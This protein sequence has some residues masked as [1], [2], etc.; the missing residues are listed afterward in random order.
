LCGGVQPG[1]NQVKTINPNAAPA[2][3]ASQSLSEHDLPNH[4]CDNSST[5]A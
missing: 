4:G 3:S 1:R 2:A 5:A